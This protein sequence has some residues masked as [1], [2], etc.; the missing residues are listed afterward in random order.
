MG[1]VNFWRFPH[2][3][4]AHGGSALLRVYAGL[5]IRVA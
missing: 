5:A 2:M 4:G 1:L 3:L